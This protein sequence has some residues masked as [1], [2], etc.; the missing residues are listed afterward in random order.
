MSS[1]KHGLLVFGG[2][3]CVT[4]K[5]VLSI[6]NSLREGCYN[7]PTIYHARKKVEFKCQS[8][9]HAAIEEIKLYLLEH[10]NQDPLSAIEDFRY[11]VDCFACEAQDGDTNFM[12]SIY[13][14]V[15]TDILDILLGMKG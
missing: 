13:Y 1:W 15:A 11:Q 4:A 6:L 2:E 10:K 3:K 12:F 9:Q 8:Y 7:S 14:D 5:N